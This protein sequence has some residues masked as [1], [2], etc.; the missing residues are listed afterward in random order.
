MSNDLMN[1]TIQCLSKTFTVADKNERQAAEAR[2][3]EL[4]GDLL[5]HFKVLL[6]TIKNESYLKSKKKKTNSNCFI[7]LLINSS[8]GAKSVCNS[9]PEKDHKEQ[10]RR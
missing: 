10:N 1:E 6:E 5:T 2:L 8:R 7:Y 3:K 4:E 9:L